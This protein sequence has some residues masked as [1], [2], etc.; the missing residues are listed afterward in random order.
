MQSVSLSNVSLEAAGKCVTS[1]E[2]RDGCG[3]LWPW[4]T[5]VLVQLVPVNFCKMRSCSHV[6]LC[7]GH[8]RVSVSCRQAA[9]VHAIDLAAFTNVARLNGWSSLLLLRFEQGSTYWSGAA[10]HVHQS[11][12]GHLR[13]S[14]LYHHVGL[15][16]QRPHC[17]E[18]QQ[19]V[20]TWSKRC[21]SSTQLFLLSARKVASFLFPPLSAPISSTLL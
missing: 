1:L 4:F 17:F 21:H 14:V 7:S 11:C 18:T 9:H 13:P 15:L 2:L 5:P 20:K 3:F 10:A 19:R 12:V 16:V 8:R 6:S